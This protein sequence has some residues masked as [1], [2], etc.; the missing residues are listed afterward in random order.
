[1]TNLEKYTRLKTLMA[2][3]T[4]IPPELVQ[5]FFA[6]DKERTVSGKA[7]CVCL[8]ISGRAARRELIARRNMLLKMATRHCTQ[9]PGEST[10]SKC[11]TLSRQRKKWARSNNENPWLLLA[12]ELGIGV[13]TSAHRLFEIVTDILRN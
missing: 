3:G 4:T 2:A 12:M 1:M 9:H 7:L 13:P 10:L 11:K 5:W 6:G 8:G